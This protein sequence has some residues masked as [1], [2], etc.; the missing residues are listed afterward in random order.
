MI[1]M[2]QRLPYTLNIP[3]APIV[4]A[5][6]ATVVTTTP[7]P[8]YHYTTTIP[9]PLHYRHERGF[10]GHLFSKEPKWILTL[11]KSILVLLCSFLCP[12]ITNE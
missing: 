3:D 7:P 10:K 6:T 2:V 1:I 11:L 4:L 12:S 5:T 8:L 9:P